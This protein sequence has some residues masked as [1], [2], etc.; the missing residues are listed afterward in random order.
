[1]LTSHR[2]SGAIA[3]AAAFITTVAGCAP[4]LSEDADD[5]ALME[6]DV[7]TAESALLAENAL[8]WNAI[9]WN[10]L[11]WNAINW[12][13]LNW[14]GL[15]PEARA[16]LQSTGSDGELARHAMRYVVSCALPST[17]SFDFSWTDEDGVAHAES[18]PGLMA[19]APQ[20]QN[21]P[22]MED[23]ARWV[24]S[25]LISRVNLYG[26]SVLLSSRSWHRELWQM[27]SEEAGTFNH[28]EGAFWGNLFTNPPTAFACY[29]QHGVAYARQRQ[30][31]CAA[32]HVNDQGA[33]ESCG[34]IQIVGSCQHHCVSNGDSLGFWGGCTSSAPRPSYS[35]NVI[36]VF[37][38]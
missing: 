6:E 14:N 33:I 29:D 31:A 12:N 32:G 20:W 5:D 30:R 11:N 9:N 26:V 2:T 38:D 37:L 28:Q 1:M 34:M 18:Y 19:L 13:A 3:L 16:R 35:F 10:A 24:S 36:T 17:A 4:P 23:E 8:N 21:A 15:L 7:D 25:C 22:I 27:S